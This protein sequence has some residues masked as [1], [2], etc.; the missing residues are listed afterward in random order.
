MENNLTAE[1]RFRA[2]LQALIRVPKA[3]VDRL[4]AERPRKAKRKKPAA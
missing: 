2:F 1:D 4:E 3:E